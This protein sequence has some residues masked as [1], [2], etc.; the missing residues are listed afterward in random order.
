MIVWLFWGC[1]GLTTWAHHMQEG[2]SGDCSKLGCDVHRH[3]ALGGAV[4]CR[5]V[6]LFGCGKR[7]QLMEQEAWLLNK[8]LR[9]HG[10]AKG[11]GISRATRHFC[12]PVSLTR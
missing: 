8:L 9:M 11:T 10:T 3:A 7:A 2:L 1:K 12:R 5:S 4:I 6:V